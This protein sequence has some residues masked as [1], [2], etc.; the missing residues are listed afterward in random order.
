MRNVA[1]FA[2]TPESDYFLFQSERSKYF[3]F[4]IGSGNGDVILMREFDSAT[5]TPDSNLLYIKD[6]NYF[7]ASSGATYVLVDARRSITIPGTAVLG[8]RTIKS[9]FQ[10]SNPSNSKTYIGFH[11]NE[12]FF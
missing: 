11:D 4:F 12:S 7:A 2:T 1:H 6:T 10:Y 3:F 9:I 5:F 8:G